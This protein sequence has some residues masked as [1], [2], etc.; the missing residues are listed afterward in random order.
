MPKHNWA[1]LPSLP[2]SGSRT[3]MEVGVAA[4]RKGVGPE[5]CLGGEGNC[6]DWLEKTNL[7]RSRGRRAGQL[8]DK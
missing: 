2:L 8:P 5:L 4:G 3:Y 1:V 6:S 7:D